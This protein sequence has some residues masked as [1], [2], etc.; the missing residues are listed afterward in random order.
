[1]IEAAVK[2]LP[3]EVLDA[4]VEDELQRQASQDAV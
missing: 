3:D 1:M 4:R 2:V